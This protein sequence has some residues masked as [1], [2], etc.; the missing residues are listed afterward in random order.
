VADTSSLSLQSPLPSPLAAQADTAVHRI[1]SASGN[2]T[3]IDKSSKDFES[4]LLSSW[5][6]QAYE[7]FGSVSGEDEDG[8][9]DSG[10]QQFQGIAMQALGTTMTASGGIGIAKMI[11]SYLH[12]KDENGANTAQIQQKGGHK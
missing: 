5:L 3:K 9:L 1:A 10:K 12:K 4:M 2:D 6:Q 11:T 7:S 8:D